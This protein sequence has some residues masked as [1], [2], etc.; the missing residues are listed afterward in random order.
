MIFDTDAAQAVAA[1]TLSGNQQ[2]FLR[3]FDAFLGCLD[4]HP[5]SLSKTKNQPAT[6]WVKAANSQLSKPDTL[7]LQRPMFAHYAQIM[8]LFLLARSS[9][10]ASIQ[11]NS[12]GSKTLCLVASVYQQWQE[13]NDI[14]RYFSLLEA[15]INRGHAQGVGEN[16]RALDD[17]FLPGYLMIF[18]DR[19]IWQ[20]KAAS[21]PAYW[22]RKGKTF[23]LAI[24]NMTGLGECQFG[25]N[26]QT[27]HSLKLTP[28]GQLFLGACRQA[29]I[30]S[31]REDEY[32]DD[33]EQIDLLATIKSIRPDV[34]HLIIQPK[35]EIAESY[36]LMVA[37]GNTC[38]RTLKVSANHLL[39]GVATAILNAFDFDNDHLYH[40]QHTNGFGAQ[41]VF[42]HPE[43]YDANGWTDETRLCQLHPVPGMEI[44]F[45]FDYGDRWEFDI[46]VG[47]GSEEVVKEITV[48]DRQGEAPEQYLS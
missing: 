26:N 28:W 20:G 21:E 13:M 12:K 19:D 39:D 3:D 42:A 29:F 34:K 8:G 4:K 14:E 47:Q 23:N 36:D 25:D 48:I 18:G 22:L 17:R 31:L 46:I 32:E 27:V 35:P 40:F 44:T 43:A 24:L 15:W 10:L 37:L 30:D 1:F 33:F 38:S 7:T 16:L 11:Q 5:A 2:D 41:K 6:K 45:L 9:G